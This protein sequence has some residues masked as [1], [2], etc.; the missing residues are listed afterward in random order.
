ME[1]VVGFGEEPTLQRVCILSYR[2]VRCLAAQG[3][4]ESEIAS[5]SMERDI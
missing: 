4:G 1:R 5:R 3:R 2:Q